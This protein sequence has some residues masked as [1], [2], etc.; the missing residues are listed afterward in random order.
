MTSMRM[1]ALIRNIAKEKNINSAVVLR[2]YVLE[3]LLKRISKS[4]YKDN[5]RDAC[6]FNRWD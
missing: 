5:G 3:R 1:K 2:N 6:S 4:K